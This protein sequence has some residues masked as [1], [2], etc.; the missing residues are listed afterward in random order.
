MSKPGPVPVPAVDRFMARVRLQPNGCWTISDI[1]AHR[2]SWI[3]LEDGTRQ[4]GHRFSYEFFVGTIPDDF[5]LDHLCRKPHCVNP[6]HLEAVTPRENYL[7]GIGPAAK[8]AAK[9]G[10]HRGHSLDA[11]NTYLYRGRRHCKSCQRER[12]REFR[13]RRQAA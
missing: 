10:C 2:Y 6:G 1:P 8:N 3:M 11:D 5:Q 9:I 4:L 13:A 7:R 12:V